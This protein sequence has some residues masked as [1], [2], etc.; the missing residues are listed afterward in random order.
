MGKRA[1]RLAEIEW[2]ER[3]QAGAGA[4]PLTAEQ[5]HR[6]A[7]EFR[8]GAVGALGVLHKI[9]IHRLGYVDG[10]GLHILMPIYVPAP[11][12]QVVLLSSLGDER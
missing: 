12:R 8:R 11:G 2:L 7:D 5:F 9:I 6:L 10:Y 4:D 1:E 3:R